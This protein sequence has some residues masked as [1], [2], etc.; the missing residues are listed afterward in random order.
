MSEVEPNDSLLFENRQMLLRL[1]ENHDLTGSHEIEISSKF[2]DREAAFAAREYVVGKYGITQG[3]LFRVVMM[4]Y[5]TY[6][7]I[8]LAFDF[9]TE[10]S[11]E[12]ITKHEM[13]LVDAA[14]KFGGETPGWEIQVKK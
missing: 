8:H 12:L 9:V 13:M 4:K 5:S 14:A 3:T 10:P 1:A 6:Q 2:S 7:T 11:A